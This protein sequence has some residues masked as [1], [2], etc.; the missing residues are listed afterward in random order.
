MTW[1]LTPMGEAIERYPDLHERLKGLS[2]A[3]AKRVHRDLSFAEG[4][5]VGLPRVRLR[6]RLLLGVIPVPWLLH[7]TLASTPAE[8]LLF[9]L[10][11][12]VRVSRVDFKHIL[13]L[14]KMRGPRPAPVFKAPRGDAWTS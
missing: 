6:L 2:P 5:L 11:G 8:R 1:Q 9:A 12:R 3:E 14:L 13:L 10:V 7:V 4:Q